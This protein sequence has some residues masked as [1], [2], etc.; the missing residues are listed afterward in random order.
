MRARRIINTKQCFMSRIGLLLLLVSAYAPAVFAFPSDTTAAGNRTVQVFKATR[1]INGGT[2][3]SL[4]AGVLDFRISHRFGQLNQGAK[5]FFGLDNA[6][7]RIGFDYGITK[8]MMVGI[9]HSVL[10][11]EDDGFLKINLLKQKENGMPV[12]V[13]YAG[14]MS[15]QTTPAPVLPNGY[16]WLLR[17]RLYYA[18]QLLIAGKFGELVSLQLMP[19]IVHYNMVDEGKFSN[20]TLAIGVGGKLRLTHRIGL[21]GEYYCRITNTDMLFNGQPTYNALS[22]G[23]EV[24]SGGHVFQLMVTNSQGL[25]ERT[26]IGQTTD[27]WAKGQLHFGFNISRIFIITTT[28]EHRP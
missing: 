21:T 8:W 4:D 26:F 24:E 5:N 1:L 22:F 20:N 14:D 12:A 3:A 7:T 19:T 28:K 23:M 16:T 2:V 18:N 15:V 11:K 10:N 9:G 6:V 27:S 17:Y 25:T 13:S